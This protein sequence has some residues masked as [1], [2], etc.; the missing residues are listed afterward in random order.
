[1]G[2]L[3]KWLINAWIALTGKKYRY[4]DYPWLR[5]PVGED[6]LIGDAYYQRFAEK[7]GLEIMKDPQGGLLKDFSVVIPENDPL[8]D[9]LLPEIAAFYEHTAAYKLEVWSQWYAPYAWFARILIR[10]LSTKMNQL[11]IPLQ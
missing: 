2:L 8:K 9:Q 11:N 6:L 1:M 4:S 3:L 5:G 10:T 7:E